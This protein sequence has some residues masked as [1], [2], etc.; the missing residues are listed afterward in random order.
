MSFWV[1]LKLKVF[2]S[3]VY[4]KQNLCRTLTKI[5]KYGSNHCKISFKIH[6]SWIKFWWHAHL[7]LWTLKIPKFFKSFEILTE[8]RYFDPLRFMLTIWVT[9]ISK[10]SFWSSFDLSS[11]TARASKIGI[12]IRVKFKKSLK[13]DQKEQGYHMTQ[14]TKISTPLYFENFLL[15]IVSKILWME[16]IRV[17]HIQW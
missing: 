6:F 14:N 4:I 17:E 16:K 13:M 2:L 3:Q 1:D 12:W 7:K 9:K 5:V 11:Q 15:G 8:S 10:S